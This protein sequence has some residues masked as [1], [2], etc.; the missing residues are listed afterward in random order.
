MGPLSNTVDLN[1]V[2]EQ[3]RKN[4]KAANEEIRKSK[5]EAAKFQ[6]KDTRDE[7]LHKI[8]MAKE[9]AKVE[10][11]DGLNIGKHLK[12][13]VGTQT[14]LAAPT[15]PEAGPGDKVPALLTPGEAVIP[16]PAAQDPRN[17]P[18]IQDMVNQGRAANAAPLGSGMAD[19]A[20][21]AI[22]QNQ[23]RTRAADP[24]V[25]GFADGT[26][27]A[28]PAQKSLLERAVEALRG[29]KP[30]DAPVGDG[31][32]RK[33]AEAVDP[34]DRKRKIEKAVNGYADGTVKVGSGPLAR[35]PGNAGKPTGA[36]FGFVNEFE[37]PN[38]GFNDGTIAVDGTQGLPMRAHVQGFN[39]GSVGV[40]DDWLDSIMNSR[41]FTEEQK[42]LAKAIY[43][44]ESQGGKLKTDQPN[45]AGARGPMQVI[46]PTF[47]GLQKQ[48]LIPADY[49]WDNPRHSSEA[50]LAL[51]Q[52]GFN[53]YGNDPD[54]IAAYYFSGP[55]AIDKSGNIVGT[56]KNAQDGKTVASYVADVRS[57]LN[58]TVTQ[59]QDT[60]YSNEGRFDRRAIEAPR[61]AMQVWNKI[62]NAA[63]PEYAETAAPTPSVMYE[64]ANG[65]APEAVPPATVMYA[66]DATPQP[67]PAITKSVT[68]VPPPAPA[69]KVMAPKPEPQ[70]T[71]LI[72]AAVDS[73]NLD[74][75]F[76]LASGVGARLSDLD[77]VLSSEDFKNKMA[78]IEKDS[79]K[80]AAERRPEEIKNWLADKFGKLFGETGLFSEREL[81]KFAVLAA[82]GMLTGGSVGGSI[83]YAGIAAMNSAERRYDTQTQARAV[84][85]A[86]AV[87]HIRNRQEKLSDN[88]NTRINQLENTY[89]QHYPK[90]TD[91]GRAA[92]S[93]LFWKAGQE[94]DPNKREMM[95]QAAIQT[96]GDNQNPTG[97]T[98]MDQLVD[99]RTGKHYEAYIG[100]DGST[101]LVSWDKDGNRVKVPPQK[102]MMLVSSND[103]N[104][105][106]NN[107]RKALEDR[108]TGTVDKMNRNRSGWINTKEYDTAGVKALSGQL[109]SELMLLRHEMGADITPDQFAA[110]AE[111]GL[112]AVKESGKSLNDV[113]PDALRR[114][115]MA[116]AVVSLRMATGSADLY[117]VKDDK[118]KPKRAN[119]D[120]IESF[121]AKLEET[122]AAMDKVAKEKAIEKGQDP[123]KISIR[124]EDAIVRLET[125]YQNLPEKD[126]QYWTSAAKG[127]P[128]VPPFLLWVRADGKKS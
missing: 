59:A 45:Y 33:A 50:G 58:G 36:L 109:T 74:D 96:L 9:L 110:I 84:Q 81:L 3:R 69:P 34:D 105:E 57:R 19:Q 11:V 13:V 43:Q 55:D 67:V 88:Y 68:E 76:Q 27:Q 22:L 49:K 112:M 119:I 38:L 117:T 123:N 89:N 6:S 35:L 8:K 46:E 75:N 31:M 99:K 18:I 51:L 128:G 65:A 12:A 120:A 40:T 42:A 54:K 124:K 30:K 21:A 29:A 60:N 10:Q 108:V 26:T 122:R 41:G 20:R 2:L 5:L 94:P 78:E 28:P 25:N 83:R 66:G 48:G 91:K 111:N 107:M 126:K 125:E 115:V 53:R 72:Q 97:S 44:Q 4:M 79:Q 80:W 104:T 121:G 113:S 98:K 101:E 86:E 71:P 82:G 37:S 77:N 114:A 32:V 85:Q 16:A 73:G 15:N 63:T 14:P 24:A 95:I 100:S 102:H 52:D 7:Q 1:M 106:Q 92:A 17:K 127:N 47:K 56:R 61:P 39:E 118:G 62:K 103:W 87:K 64:G 116:N 93:Q 70:L 23:M 90:A